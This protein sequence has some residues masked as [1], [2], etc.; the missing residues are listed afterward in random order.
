MAPGALSQ[1]G[2]NAVTP[3]DFVLQLPVFMV[4]VPDGESFSPRMGERIDDNALAVCLFTERLHAERDCDTWRPDAVIVQIDTSEEFVELAKDFAKYL[5]V[6][7]V[8]IDPASGAH[9][10]SIDEITRGGK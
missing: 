7:Y 6:K 2:D 5:K 4:G 10:I 1:W 9:W 8:A 3:T